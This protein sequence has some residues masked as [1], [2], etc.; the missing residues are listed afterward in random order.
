MPPLYRV[1][2]VQ[3]RDRGLLDEAMG[4]DR[5]SRESLT[6]RDARHFGVPGDHLYLFVEAS[7]EGALRAEALLLPFAERAPEGDV[8]YQML[9]EEEERAA[10]SLGAVF[11][12]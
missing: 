1:F 4:D 2:K 10:S 9:K 11:G 6:I 8:L 3:A 12:D 5:L 7:P